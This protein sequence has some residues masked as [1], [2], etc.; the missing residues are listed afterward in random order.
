[1]KDFFDAPYEQ[2]YQPFKPKTYGD[3]KNHLN[4]IET[5]NRKNNLM[6]NYN[7]YP[8]SFRGGIAPEYQNQYA[9]QPKKKS[10]CRAK[11]AKNG[12]FVINGWKANKA[13]LYSFFATPTKHTDTVSS[14]RGRQWLTGYVVEIKVRRSNGMTY[15]VLNPKKDAKGNASGLWWALVDKMTGKVIIKDCGLVMNPAGGVGGVV[16]R[17]GG[18]PRR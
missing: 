9:P 8:T 16:A 18:K 7:K 11:T 17:I 12:K 10:G 1:M 15:P 13:G 5:K 14:E 3:F 4:K 2:P 6:K